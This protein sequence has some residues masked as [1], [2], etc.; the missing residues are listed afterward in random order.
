MPLFPKS[1]RALGSSLY[2]VYFRSVLVVRTFCLGYGKVTRKPLLGL[3]DDNSG[4]AYEMT[5]PAQ[6][7]H[8]VD[9][10]EWGSVSKICEKSLGI[11]FDQ[12]QFIGSN[13]IDVLV[14]VSPQNFKN[15]PVH[16]DAQQLAE[17]DGRVVIITT[18]ETKD[19]TE[20]VHSRGFAPRYG[21][22]ED[23][24]TGSAHCAIGPYWIEKL[25]IAQGAWLVARQGGARQGVLEVTFN[26]RQTHVVIRGQAIPTIIGRLSPEI[27]ETFRRT[28]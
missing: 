19:S 5:F 21:I 18:R 1:K 23:P 20:H 15:I 2:Q 3:K 16:A 26:E 12:I 6:P 10:A 4:L 11:P 24:V 9:D 22:N 27:T 17:I 13:Q 25:G 8:Q 14:E 28:G 7:V